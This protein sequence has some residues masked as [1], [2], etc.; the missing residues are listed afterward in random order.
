MVSF[1]RRIINRLRDYWNK[2]RKDRLYPSIDDIDLEELSDIWDDYG[3][4]IKINYSD[5]KGMTDYQLTHIGKKIVD[6]HKEHNFEYNIPIISEDL[7][8]I[9]SYIE[10]VIDS[11]DSVID[12]S[13][14]ETMEYVLKFR[15]CF[16]PLGKND[17]KV[18]QI[19]GAFN[20]FFL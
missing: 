3:F 8:G 16:L 7:E 4:L 1:E 17:N 6:L 14:A 15:Q 18:D 13:E 2:V 10:S 11:K 19:I 20:Y 5:K 9:V 12:E